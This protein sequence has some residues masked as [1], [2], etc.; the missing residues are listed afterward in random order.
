MKYLDT[1]AGALVLGLR[2]LWI[3]LRQTPLDWIAALAIFWMARSLAPE[4]SRAREI[5]LAGL[6]LWLTAL[7][8]VSQG[9]ETWA[10]I[11]WR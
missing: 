9:P 8:A 11:S 1:L 6:G 2:L 7:Y 4:N 3:P 10:L 5:L